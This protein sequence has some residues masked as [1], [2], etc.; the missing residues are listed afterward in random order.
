MTRTQIK[1]GIAGSINLKDLQNLL[2]SI[3]K[4][5]QL[6]RLNLVDFNQIANDC[7][8]T[9]VI[10][11]QDNNVKNFSDLRDLLRKCLK[12]TSELDQIED[13]FDNQ[14]IKTLQ[15]AW[16]IIIN[17]LAENIIEWIE[18]ELVVVEI[19]QT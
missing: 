8:I 4:R 11:S 13:D 17:D 5:Y 6:I 19:I 14:N 2:K 10:F 12:N 16:K 7:E 1:F 9:L 18:E 15:E 3:S